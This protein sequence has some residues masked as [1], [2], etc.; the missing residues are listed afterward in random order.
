M[1]WI[2]CLFL[3]VDWYNCGLWNPQLY[4]FLNAMVDRSIIGADP[5]FCVEDLAKAASKKVVSYF[6]GSLFAH[7]VAAV[8]SRLNIITQYIWIDG[9]LWSAWFWNIAIVVVGTP[10]FLGFKQFFLTNCAKGEMTSGFYGRNFYW[11]SKK[12]FLKYVVFHDFRGLWLCRGLNI[13]RTPR[14]WKHA[15]RSVKLGQTYWEALLWQMQRSPTTNDS[16]FFQQSRQSRWFQLH[17][18][19]VDIF[20]IQHLK[21]YGKHTSSS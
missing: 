5:A 2:L 16:W 19:Q 12:L 1:V 21:L 6:M 20:C 18:R 13:C 17:L 14:L 10:Q 8:F 4:W 3:V 15:I 9:V 11:L 7:W